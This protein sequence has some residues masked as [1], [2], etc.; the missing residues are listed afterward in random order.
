MEARTEFRGEGISKSLV[1]VVAVSITMALGVGAGV[2]AKNLSLTAAP[3]T[4]ISQG[5]GGAAQ[6]NPA[7]RGGVQIAGGQAPANSF[8]GPDAQE[9]NATLAAPSARPT[10]ANAR[11]HRWI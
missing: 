2:A 6:E 10:L 9:R 7:R 1:V 4:H 3:K 8:L 5:L 11:G